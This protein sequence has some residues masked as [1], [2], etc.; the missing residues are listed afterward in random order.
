MAEMTPM[1]RQYLETK[2]EYPDAILMYRLGDFYEMF[3]DDAKTASRELE[4]VLTGRDCGMPE[5][6]P[7][8][9]VPF[10][11][12]DG[13]LARLVAKGYKVAIC[14]QMEDP[15][16]AKGIVKREVIRVVTP[17]TVIESNMLDESKNNYLACI[18][19]EGSR[20]GICF[21][22]V[23]TGSVH[24]THIDSKDVQ[25]KIIN[26]LGRYTPSE[27]IYNAQAVSGKKLREFVKNR[28]NCMADGLPEESLDYGENLS[29]VLS[30]FSVNDVEELGVSG[31]EAVIALGA[32]LRYLQETQKSSV[33]NIRSVEFYSE[34]QFMKIDVSSR[35]NLELTETMRN[36]EKKGTLLWVLD[37]TCTA[38]GKRLIRSW[39][40]QPLVS[41]PKIE[42]RHHAVSE[43][44]ENPISLDAIKSALGGVV[45]MERLMARIVYGTANAKELRALLA[46]IKK[47]P[48]LKN[49]LEG[50]ES[51]LLK[52]LNASLD[53]LSDI[54][55]LIESSICEDPPFTVRE[56]GMIRDGF[57][58]ELDS[59][60][61]I[62]VNGKGYI[63]KVQMDEQEKTGIKKLKIG[64]NRVFGY[65][66]EI[67]NSFKELV[68]EG[69]I[70]KQTL[71]SCERY[72]TQ[73]L[74]ELESK[75]LGAQERIV[76]LEY[77]IFSLVR[78]KVA[79]EYF[80]IQKTAA[81]I[82]AVDALCSFADVSLKNGYVCPVMTEKPVIS[83]KDGRH[84]VVEKM[85]KD[86]PFVP[87]DTLLDCGENR[88]AIITGPNM[89]GKS[90][91]M[92]Q[93]ALI[94]L[95]AQCGCFVPAASAEIGITD[96][97]FTRVGA[98]DDLASG[99]ST[100]MVEMS[101]VANILKN[102]TS[103]S[104][105]I[106]DEIGR[107]T[108]TFDGMSI[109]RA[110]LEH[111]ADKKKLGAKTLFATHYHELTE[112][113]DKLDG[114][115][116]YNIAVKK[117][118]DDI[119]F[120]RRIVRGGADGS[121]GIEVAKLAGVPNSVVNRARAIL[122]ELE[123]TAAPVHMSETPKAED[124]DPLMQLSFAG[125]A[126]NEII[127]ELKTVDVNTLTPIEAM[128]KLY[129]MVNEAKKI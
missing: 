5:R 115:K 1:M 122:K 68:P 39:I 61:D 97:I 64:Y 62:V 90:T 91:Y 16:T 70:R 54:E 50:F 18:I 66:I 51:Q 49:E 96:S 33:D 112:L 41:L 14:E 94:V 99:Q 25:S 40:E 100:F 110:V 88:C 47:I 11:S 42:K 120:L 60:R 108:S 109:A 85:M 111:T 58:T 19:A 8:C 67:P 83:I 26:E 65:Y 127:D 116:N 20:A 105:L 103:K 13:Y 43:I 123:E 124:N 74:K 93:V 95:M 77:E 63:A 31:E 46:A 56:G 29:L 121:Y 81:A 119:T 98:S 113:E 27:I 102:A 59:L 71:A 118:G 53:T 106:F 129:E 23:S 55:Q 48:A 80:R 9:G 6:A 101:E 128:Q 125:G 30:H 12:V 79:D 86:S 76:K 32:T 22:D 87:N 82:A 2:K 114:V 10:H 35:R 28:L 34:S 38:M 72:I 15:A 3:F 78:G 117:R 24:L 84:P 17:G 69:Y 126:G 104:L 36:R 73:E 45:D 37:K 44:T 57:N 89:A 75:V 7:M 21:A 107:G 92:R 52:E 4:L